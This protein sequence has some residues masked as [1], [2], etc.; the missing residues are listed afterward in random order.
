MVQ[1]LRITLRYGMDMPYTASHPHYCKFAADTIRL[2]EPSLL[3]DKPS[4]WR[5]FCKKKMTLV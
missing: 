3:H 2:I 5:N 4:V 1:Y